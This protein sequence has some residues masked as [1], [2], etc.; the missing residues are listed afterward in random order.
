VPKPGSELTLALSE[1]FGANKSI[2]FHYL[3]NTTGRAMI[4]KML[5]WHREGKFPVEKI[6]KFFPIQDAVQA[7]HG[8]ESGAVIKPVLVW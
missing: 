6:I 2:E 7:L 5:Q 3:G 1:M 8:M 4:P